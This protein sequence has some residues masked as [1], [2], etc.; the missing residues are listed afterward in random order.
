MAKKLKEV[1]EQLKGAVVAHGKQAKIIENHIKEMKDGPS[2]F[3]KM[4]ER[5]KRRRENRKTMDEA[6]E[7][8]RPGL[9]PFASFSNENRRPG[10]NPFSNG[11]GSARPNFGEN[12]QNA[13]GNVMRGQQMGMQMGFNPGNI[14]PQPN[15]GMP[16]A[17]PMTTDPAMMGMSMAAKPKQVAKA[18]AKEYANKKG[19]RGKARKELIKDAKRSQSFDAAAQDEKSG[20]KPVN[21]GGS[22]K[23]NGKKLTNTQK[24]FKALNKKEVAEKRLFPTTSAKGRINPVG[25]NVTGYRDKYEGSQGFRNAQFGKHIKSSLASGTKA[26]VKKNKKKIKRGLR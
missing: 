5:I 19:L 14:L 3:D 6:R 1:V 22:M 20:D 4:G 16:P 12:A 9:N 26:E 25:Q 23:G 17:D 8:P 7:N 2:F 13:I 15:P 18:Q 11:T 10:F 21:F 24:D